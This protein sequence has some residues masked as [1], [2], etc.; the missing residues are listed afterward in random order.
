MPPSRGTGAANPVHRSNA[1]KQFA[2][3]TQRLAAAVLPA[4]V[5]AGVEPRR[6]GGKNI[7][8]DGIGREGVTGRDDLK[9]K[10]L[11]ALHRLH[12]LPHLIKGFFRDPKLRYITA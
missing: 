1:V 8:H 12:R 6:V 4:G 2:A 11:A 3:S 5:C 10:E 9:A 7:K